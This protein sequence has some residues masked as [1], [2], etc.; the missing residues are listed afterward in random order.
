LA[1]QKETVYCFAGSAGFTGG[2]R[3]DNEVPPAF[4]D[5][6]REGR[7]GPD[8]PLLGFALALLGYKEGDL[9]KASS[10]HRGGLFL[11]AGCSGFFHHFS[12]FQHMLKI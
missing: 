9:G 1:E 12:Y 3:F 6:D 8:V 4:A 2:F 11:N 10:H 5:S 7:I